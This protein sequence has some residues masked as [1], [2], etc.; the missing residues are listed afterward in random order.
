M[1]YGCSP[2]Q[3]ERSLGGVRQIDDIPQGGNSPAVD[4]SHSMAPMIRDRKNA[5]LI[6]ILVM[7][8]TLIPYLF[9]AIDRGARPGLGWFSGFTFNATD[10]CVYLSWMKQAA[11]GGFFQRN[12]FT[13][14][15]QL[16]HQFNLFFLVLGWISGITH[17]SPLVVYQLA[18]LTLGVLLLRSIWWLLEL[19]VVPQRA[20]WASYLVICFSAGF[21]WVPG[22]WELGILRGPIDTWQPEAITFLSLYL[23]PLFVV[24]LLLMVGIIGN[25]WRA[26]QS[27]ETKFA[28]YAGICGFLLGNV[29]TYDVIT[30]C[31]VWLAYCVARCIKLGRM[32][33]MMLIHAAVAGIP[34]AV[35]TG[36][37]AF[38]LRSETVFRQRALVPTVWPSGGWLMIASG[39]GA[40]LLLSGL[41]LYM[42]RNRPNSQNLVTEG[43]VQLLAAWAVMNVGASYIPISFQR[44]MIMGTHIPLSILAG[45]AIYLILENKTNRVWKWGVAA[46]TLVLSFTN[47]RFLINDIDRLPANEPGVR[48]FLYSG[49]MDALLWIRDHTDKSAAIQPLPWVTLAENGKLAFFDNS[50]ACYAPG[51]TGHPVNAG[52]WGE[53]PEFGKT[54]NR[55]TRF[56]SA[57]TPDQ[58]KIDL[59][60]ETGVQY[61]IFTQRHDETG[62]A[63][64]D[65]PAMS[66]FLGGT[67][68][69]LERIPQASNDDA[70]V[71]KVK[72]P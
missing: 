21:G 57:D 29:H 59:L 68:S 18:R 66:P 69:F 24:S 70:D 38:L 63:D 58:Y 9:G 47:I 61:I 22:V 30:V 8:I 43:G 64:T 13:T 4:P 6:A 36:Y 26:E 34:T 40:V 72:L 23:F 14:S 35:T 65:G 7:G 28:V 44:K 3:K 20:K 45:V 54:M 10:H 1:Y 39:F 37:M 2:Y 5:L 17:L 15:R 11:D 16:G 48:S 56:L 52:H 62:R 31:G 55:W 67:L 19:W 12:L 33:K 49:E 27:G 42:L 71:F 51:I 25:L 53:T 60:R 41:A 50:V 46:F 32:P